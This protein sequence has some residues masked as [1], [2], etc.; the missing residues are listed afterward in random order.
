MAAW[1]MS[2]EVV[3]SAPYTQSG[4]NSTCG[5][6]RLLHA[7]QE[8]AE[9]SAFQV[10]RTN[11]AAAGEGANGGRIEELEDALGHAQA[12]LVGG[13]GLTCCAERGAE[14]QPVTRSLRAP[15]GEGEGE[16]CNRPQ[17][18]RMRGLSHLPHPTT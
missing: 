4:T 14:P 1:K 12:G 7:D 15:V 16:E 8:A 11:S 13:A 9:L 6:S 3:T 18:Q 5:D 10:R 2:N 17:F